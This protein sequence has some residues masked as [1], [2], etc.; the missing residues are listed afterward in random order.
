MCRTIEKYWSLS[1]FVQEHPNLSLQ[2]SEWQGLKILPRGNRLHPSLPIWNLMVPAVLAIRLRDTLCII[3]QGVRVCPMT[4]N[5]QWWGAMICMN[6]LKSGHFLKEW[7]SSYHCRNCQKLH[8]T[9]QHVDTQDSQ[10]SDSRCFVKVLGNWRALN[11]WSSIIFWR[12]KW[13]ESFQE[14]SLPK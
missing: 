10:S 4:G 7:K 9:F 6:C 13:F 1:I 8:H 2:T 11:K 5:Y 14:K 3:A 12:T